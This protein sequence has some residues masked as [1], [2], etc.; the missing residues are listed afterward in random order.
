MDTERIYQVTRHM[1]MTACLHTLHNVHWCCTLTCEAARPRGTEYQAGALLHQA[2]Y[3]LSLPMLCCLPEFFAMWLLLALKPRCT[4][5][6]GHRPNSF[7]CTP[8][9]GTGLLISRRR[10]HELN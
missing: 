10:R 8:Q 2:N 3:K 9:R 5:A 6:H 1:L 4:L 7:Q